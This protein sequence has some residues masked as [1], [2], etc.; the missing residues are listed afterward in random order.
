MSNPEIL[1]FAKI[2]VQHVRDATIQSCDNTILKN[3]QNII[4]ERWRK[5]ATGHGNL[6]SIAKVLV[7]DIVDETLFHLLRAIDQETLR[8]SFT[9]SDG[10]TVDLVD[11]GYG[12][13]AGW[14]VGSEAWRAMYSK[15]RFF[16]DAPD[17]K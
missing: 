9:A 16:D 3:A 15:E 11:E 17:I 2:L 6:D 13:L 1:E 5:A 4:A 14:Y 12:E 7:P 10:K 8:L